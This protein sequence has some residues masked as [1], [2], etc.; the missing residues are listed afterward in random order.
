MDLPRN[1][2]IRLFKKKEV[3]YRIIHQN[4]FS[5]PYDHAPLRIVSLAPSQTEFLHDLELGD[6]VAGITKFCIHPAAWHQTKASIGGTKNVAIEK[7]IE[8]RPDLIIANK[9]ENVKEQVEAL[10]AFAPVYVSDVSTLDDAC[11]MMLQVGLLN[12]KG[13]VAE[14]WIREIAEKF[15]EL[16]T[17]VKTAISSGTLSAAYLIWRKPY[18]AAGGDTFIDDML[19]RCGLRNAFGHLTRYP[20]VTTEDL[21]K[22]NCQLLLLSSEPYPFQQKH[23]EELQSHLPNTK[24]LLVDGE[25]FSW[26]G[27]RLLK[28]PAYFNQLLLRI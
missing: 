20:Q 10:A 28:A 9:E 5:I 25:M 15:N 26:Y 7:V 2:I 21:Q 14:I 3:M 1:N 6:R 12:G 16:E 27:S 8:L 11:E 13:M 4:N 23:M 17:Q 24:I 22:S 19:T 18:M